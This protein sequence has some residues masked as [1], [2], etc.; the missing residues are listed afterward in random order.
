M[1]VLAVAGA[2]AIIG[3]GCGEL[4]EPGS[5]CRHGGGAVRGEGLRFAKF[6]LHGTIQHICG[7]SARGS[8][9]VR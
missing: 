4:Q 8:T 5:M 2:V 3:D 1:H 9:L 6:H 7:Q